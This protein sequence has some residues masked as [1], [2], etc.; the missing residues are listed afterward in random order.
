MPAATTTSSS[1]SRRRT[2]TASRRTWRR[3][4]STTSSWPRREEQAAWEAKTGTVQD[5]I[6]AVEEAAK[7]RPA[8]GERARLTRGDRGRSRIDCPD[9][10]PTIPSTWN[11]FA[12]T[13]RDPR[14]EA[15]RLGEQGRAGRPATARASW[16]PTI[17]PSSPPTSPIPAPA[18]P[19]GWSTPDHPLT[20]RVFVNR[21][22]QHHFGAGLVKT[23]NDFGTKGDRPEPSRAARL[24]GGDARRGRL[25][26]RSRSIACWS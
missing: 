25:A 24:A 11:D 23:V 26:A 8:G 13:D 17:S 15:G 22:W 3:P 10:L 4:R 6:A 16:C 2:T 12:E 19:V 18:W 9:P 20:A 14:P 21:L 7:A 5:E 1:R